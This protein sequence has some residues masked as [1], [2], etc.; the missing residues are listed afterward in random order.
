M[1]Y[2]GSDKDVVFESPVFPATGSS[3]DEIMEALGAFERQDVDDIHS[4]N[5]IQSTTLMSHMEAAQIAKEANSMFLRRN[6]LYQT[7]LPGTTRLAVEVK[8]MIKE[9]LGFPQEARTRFTSGGSESLYCAIHSAKQ[10]GRREKGIDKPEIVVPYSIHAAFSKWCSYADIKINRIRLG[11]DYRA[12][13][14][15]MEAAVNDNTVM[16]AGSAPCWPYGLFDDI[17]GIAGI[18]QR[19]DLWMHVDGCLGGFQSPFAEKL[20]HPLPQWDFRVPGVRSISADLHKHAYSAKPLSSITFRDARWEQYL[21]CPASD[22]PDGPY[23]SEA[24]CGTTTAGPVASAWAVM[25]YLGEEGYLE[26]MRRSLAVRQRYID[27]L[28][29]IDGVE[30]FVSDMCVLTI[31]PEKGLD[32]FAIM[33]GLYQRKSF[34]LPSLQPPAM[35]VVLDPVTD[36]VVDTFVRDLA[37]VIPLVR[38]GSITIEAIEPYM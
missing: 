36:E 14:Q 32:M 27:K 13:V 34:C 8:Q 9:M 15:A 6:M 2:F 16:V 35:K 20:G 31:R 26:L 23:S 37:E 22:W 29:A 30:P 4:H 3:R 18:A 1:G 28:T 38:E 7:L 5:T 10:W 12:D 24:I 11:A 17:P 19:H 25:K 33:G 21:D